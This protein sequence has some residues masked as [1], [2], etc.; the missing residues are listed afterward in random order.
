MLDESVNGLIEPSHATP[1]R[2]EFKG[3][4]LSGIPYLKQRKEAVLIRFPLVFRRDL[5]W[6][7]WRG[8]FETLADHV[9]FN[10]YGGLDFA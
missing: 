3:K 4:E 2:R 5:A 9:G 6:L 10:D 8:T 7:G 1:P